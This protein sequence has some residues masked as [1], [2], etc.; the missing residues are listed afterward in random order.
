[1]G[2]CMDW[3]FA[4]HLR[5]ILTPSNLAVQFLFRML[6]HCSFDRKRR[7]SRKMPVGTLRPCVSTKYIYVR[8]ALKPR[9]SGNRHNKFLGCDLFECDLCGNFSLNVPA[10][11]CWFSSIST[12]FMICFP[13]IIHSRFTLGVWGLRLYWPDVAQPSATVG[14]RSRATVWELYG[15]AYGES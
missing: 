13:Q 3:H 5:S 12:F 7:C 14:N 6:T 11:F 9:L 15:R 2:P 8:W 1:M 4:Y 10:F